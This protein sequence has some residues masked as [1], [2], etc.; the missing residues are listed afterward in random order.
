MNKNIII[1]ALVIACGILGYDKVTGSTTDLTPY[2]NQ[3]AEMSRTVDSLKEAC[4]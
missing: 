2:I 3:I 4:K 1:L